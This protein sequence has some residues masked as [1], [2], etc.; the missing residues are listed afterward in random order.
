MHFDD[1]LPSTAHLGKRKGREEEPA[2]SGEGDPQDS[3]DEEW[4]SELDESLGRGSAE[5]ETG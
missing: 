1:E 3:V 4:E 2:G 5:I